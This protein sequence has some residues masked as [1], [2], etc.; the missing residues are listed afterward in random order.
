MINI[1]KSV[2]KPSKPS[3]EEIQKI[4]KENIDHNTKIPP[5]NILSKAPFVWNKIMQYLNQNDLLNCTQV[6]KR[7]AEIAIKSTGL[8]K[9]IHFNGLRQFKANQY[10]KYFKNPNKI[11]QISI[12]I[13]P[14]ESVKTF[15]SELKDQSHIKITSIDAR[16]INTLI[17]KKKLE[18]F[19]KL[20]DDHKPSTIKLT[21]LDIAKT[22]S[23][24]I[25]KII[26]LHINNPKKLNP[27]I[28]N[29]KNLPKDIII[30]EIH[31]DS[32]LIHPDFQPEFRTIF[33]LCKH[34]K[35]IY[36]SLFQDIKKLKIFF[37][38]YAHLAP[39]TI[40]LKIQCLEEFSEEIKNLPKNTTIQEVFLYPS[41]TI[42]VH[43]HQCVLNLLSSCN[44]LEQLTLGDISE[45]VK[46]ENLPK[47]LKTFTCNEIGANS[48]L[49]FNGLQSLR[50]IT[51][52][53][54]NGKIT[55]FPQKIHCL[56]CDHINVTGHLDLAKV[57]SIKEFNTSNIDGQ[58]SLSENVNITNLCLRFPIN[59]KN[60]QII[61][62]LISSCKNLKELSVYGLESGC[63]I[64][65]F[66]KTLEKFT[67]HYLNLNSSL[68]F[69]D[70][71]NLKNIDIHGISGKVTNWPK[72][73]DTL[74]LR[75]INSIGFLDFKNIENIQTLEIKGYL[76]EFFVNFP[77]QTSHIIIDGEI[78]T[79]LDFKDYQNIDKLTIMAQISS[80]SQVEIL[81]LP[82]HINEFVWKIN[83]F[84]KVKNSN[85][86]SNIKTI[87]KFTILGE[88][89]P[90]ITELPQS[91]NELH[92]SSN[93]LHHLDQIKDKNIDKVILIDEK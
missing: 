52:S 46:I 83:S 23:S 89:F 40:N 44:T 16:S 68:D 65:K 69:I 90:P 53:H 27:L 13:A 35:Q 59:S 6:S 24:E 28:E 8:Y 17:S 1:I 29:L 75:D 9:N 45:N 91:I 92:I 85:F 78:L 55:N 56:H 10:E 70:T 60:N 32:S 64:K 18:I 80:Y 49:D 2:D 62:K 21:Y 51:V 22:I 72:K 84:T 81:N 76:R 30:E 4:V 36:P 7:F 31:I 19:Y 42:N 93:I 15:Q 26:S 79:N 87:K 82:K 67:S 34:L 77:H 50:C 71:P 88:I 12:E 33:D 25:K 37:E 54:I 43:N 11:A 61:L 14:A 74:V 47:N 5:I 3:K 39:S 41:C 66:P 86:L 63:N 48:S 58:I 57:Q 38:Y 73:I 20:I